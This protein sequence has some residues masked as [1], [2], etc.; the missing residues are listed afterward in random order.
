MAAVHFTTIQC[1]SYTA[2]KVKGKPH[3]SH[4]CNIC[5]YAIDTE[6]S[7]FEDFKTLPTFL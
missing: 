7:R 6:Y 4:V 2:H 5:F 3:I 1:E